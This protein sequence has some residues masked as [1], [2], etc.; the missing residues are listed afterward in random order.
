MSDYLYHH[1]IL[2]QRWGIR[3]FR[4]KDG[5]LTSAGKKRY[6]IKEQ[7]K[8]ANKIKK[9]AQKGKRDTSYISKSIKNQEQISNTMKEYLHLR[10]KW[11]S[12]YYK[13]EDEYEEATYRL[14]D[15]VDKE[16]QKHGL[17]PDDINRMYYEDEILST[18]PMIKMLE[19]EEE[20]A[21]NE[22]KNSEKQICDILLGEYGE[23]PV[24]DH[25]DGRTKTTSE[26]VKTILNRI[27]K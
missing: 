19:A 18:D 26:Y 11:K 5:S 25:Y 12:A 22:Y 9:D 20:K 1:G 10:E 6:G 24:K 15:K 4:N 23:Q 8:L 17:D 21:Y 16:M 2:G 14:S 3:R 7:G 27:S 13:C